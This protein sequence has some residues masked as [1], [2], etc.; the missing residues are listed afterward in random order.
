MLGVRPNFSVYAQSGAGRHVNKIWS[1]FKP[2]TDETFSSTLAWVDTLAT[3]AHGTLYGDLTFTFAS[4]NGPRR[5][6]YVGD[7]TLGTDMAL[8]TNLPEPAEAPQTCRGC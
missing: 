2:D 6:V 1:K 4:Y 3:C 7:N 5:P 8:L